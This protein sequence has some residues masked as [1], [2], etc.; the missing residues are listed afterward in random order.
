[1][2]LSCSLCLFAFNIKAPRK[3]HVLQSTP[4]EE[5]SVQLMVVSFQPKPEQKKIT[6]HNK[7]RSRPVE[8]PPIVQVVS[9]MVATEPLQAL[10]PIETSSAFI[11][12]KSLVGSSRSIEAYVDQKPSYPGG[13]TALMAFLYENLSN[14][15]SL[16][17]DEEEG[18]MML[19]FVIDEEGNVTGIEAKKNTMSEQ[20]LA[21]VVAVMK[22]M[23][24]WNPG[25]L[26]G[27]PVKTQFFQ[28]FTFRTL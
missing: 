21:E 1:M 10:R 5:E 3:S 4:E 19:R 22:R 27:E 6:S 11:P 13:Q 18:E 17:L 14:S 2:S 8:A 28:P 16:F 9:N 15:S 25:L 23:P 7:P 24:R 12:M 26:A 20:A